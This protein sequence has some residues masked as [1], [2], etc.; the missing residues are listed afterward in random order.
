MSGALRPYRKNAPTTGHRISD[1][2]FE[3]WR[4]NA[5]GRHQNDKKILDSVFRAAELAC[6]KPHDLLE[7]CGP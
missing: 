5:I 6:L 7:T 4:C 1:R 3:I 2:L